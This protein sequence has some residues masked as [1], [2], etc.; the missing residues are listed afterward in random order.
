MNL[1]LM[2]K[3]AT[4]PLRRS[5]VLLGLMSLS[6]AQVMLA[7]WFSGGVQQEIRHTEAYA[8]QARFVTVQLKEEANLPGSVTV[9]AIRDELRGQ[10]VGIEELKTEDVLARMETEEPDVVQTVRS[11]GNQGLQLMPKLLLVRGIIA[12]SSI[13]KIKMMTDVYK[14]DVSPVHHARLVSFYQHLSLELRIVIFLIMFLVVVQLLV[15]QRIQQRDLT[16]VLRNLVSWGVNGIQARLPGFFSILVLSSISFVVSIV[17]WF[18]FQKLVWN[19]NAFLGELSLDRTLAL[20][21]SLCA[22]T[23]F[24]VLFMGMILSFSGRSIEE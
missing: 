2:L 3:L 12:D 14:L 19:N 21:Y 6:F 7:L 16:E 10:D 5:W 13:E 22:L 9:E 8:K 17:E 24:A 1:R 23:F 18:I 15:F 11:I 4:I 20:P